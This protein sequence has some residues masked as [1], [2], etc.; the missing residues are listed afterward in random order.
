MQL[1]IIVSAGLEIIDV[2]LTIANHVDIIYVVTCIG[3]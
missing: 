1:Y 2:N 3:I